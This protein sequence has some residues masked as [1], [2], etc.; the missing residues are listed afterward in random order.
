MGAILGKSRFYALQS[1]PTSSGLGWLLSVIN[2]SVTP[3]TYSDE[4][5]AY[6]KPAPH[7]SPIGRALPPT[8]MGP[9]G[10]LHRAPASFGRK[11]RDSV[12]GSSSAWRRIQSSAT[13]EAS[14]FTQSR[15][16]QS[17]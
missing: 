3:Y 14:S 17:W 2:V 7:R 6:R 11:S 4:R 9:R 1:G 5:P 12:S 16:P 13:C 15:V 10:V 8:D